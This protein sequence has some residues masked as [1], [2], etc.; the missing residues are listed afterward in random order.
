MARHLFKGCV[1]CA[2][3]THVEDTT[4]SGCPSTTNG[5]AGKLNSPASLLG[6]EQPRCYHAS[7]SAFSSPRFL[8]AFVTSSSL[9][10]I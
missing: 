10:V 6:F 1:G 9:P 5:G 7:Q 2:N 3:E 8:V 4:V